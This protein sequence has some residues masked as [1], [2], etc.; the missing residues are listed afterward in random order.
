MS[1]INI[2]PLGGVREEGKNMY[3]VEINQ[4]IFVL[5]CG[6]L[7]PEDDLLGIDMVIPDFTYL[8]ENADRVVGIFLSHG[9]ADAVG[10]LPY[11]L[12]KINA[13]VFGTHLTIELASISARKQGLEDRIENFFEID[14]ET[15]IEFDEVTVSFFRTTHTIPDSVGIVLETSEGSI[16]YTGDFRFDPSASKFYQTD[17]G[18][19]TDI[20]EG[21]VIA[22]LSDSA[23]AESPVENV[24]DLMIS[25]EITEVFR[26]AKGRVIVGTIGSNIARIQQ[27]LEAAYQSKRT[28]FIPSDELYEIVDV[29]IQLDKINIPSRDVIGSF[30]KVDSFKDNQVVIL[31]TGDVGE[32]IKTIQAMA[33]GN[34]PSVRI[35]EHD[36]VYI[37]TTPSV[38]METSVARTKD[39]IY[40]AG[41]S[42]LSVTDHHKTSGHATPN[43]LKLMLN[44]IKPQYLIPI[45]GEYR[46]L[47]AHAD[48]AT[49]VGMKPDQVVILSLGDVLEYKNGKMALSGQVDAGDVLVDGIGVGDIGNVV[50]RDRRVLSEDGIFVVVAT[51]SRR[52]KKILVGPQITS[53][54]FVFMKTSTDLIEACS[55]ITLDVL[56]EHLASDDFDWGELKG[57]L[58]EKIGKFLFKETKRRPV[59]LPIIMEASNYQAKKD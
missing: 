22:L 57:D 42:V 10:A 59:V 55:D 53:R 14:S 7:F 6:L 41:A 28:I 39:M 29:A 15:E 48:L 47:K 33:Q 1:N 2:I 18:R 23:A 52:L 27:V 3:I 38:S 13:P 49:Q 8:E 40:K 30:K 45:N 4:A 43:D 46:M 9:H 51:I 32:P 24:S 37:A 20:G 54:G 16:V 31:A 5:D 56:D 35:K 50:L 44:F 25:E 21:N 36:T 58:R 26:N 17:F 34:H 12:N 11:L 19:L